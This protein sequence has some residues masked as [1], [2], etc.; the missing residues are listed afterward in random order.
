MSTRI[1]A[2]IQ[3]SLQTSQPSLVKL[4]HGSVSHQVEAFLSQ[5][6]HGGI[7]GKEQQGLILSHREALALAGQAF[8]DKYHDNPPLPIELEVWA[9]KIDHAQSLNLSYPRAMNAALDSV[10]AILEV[11]PFIRERC[12][13]VLAPASFQLVVEKTLDALVKAI[14]VLNA[15]TITTT[16]VTLMRSSIH[17][18]PW[19][20]LL[21][22]QGSPCSA[23]LQLPKGKTHRHPLSLHT[24]THRLEASPL[25][26]TSSTYGAQPPAPQP[27]PCPIGRDT[28]IA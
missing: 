21:L 18:L 9:D 25:C 6:R 8:L 14:R 26:K 7:V 27:L 23:F 16:T 22:T 24:S 28:L 20:C 1:S 12:E 19:E 15:R 13:A 3:V 10:S 4:R 2:V 5:A 17:S 11:G